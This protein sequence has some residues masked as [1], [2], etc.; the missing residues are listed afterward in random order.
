MCGIPTRR[1]RTA[2]VSVVVRTVG[3]MEITRHTCL[4]FDDADGDELLCA[5]GSR[6]VAEIDAETGETVLVVLADAP[7]RVLAAIA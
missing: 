7:V 5:C 4:W 6:A 3:G 1:G 2:V